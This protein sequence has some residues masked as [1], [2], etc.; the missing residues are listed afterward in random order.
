MRC[1]DVTI[2]YVRDDAAA[3]DENENVVDDSWGCF[4]SV[5]YYTCENV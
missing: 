1:K 2:M 5:P 3:D 4:L